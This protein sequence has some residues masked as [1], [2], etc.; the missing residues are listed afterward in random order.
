MSYLELWLQCWYQNWATELICDLFAIYTL[1][2]AYAWAHV[3]LCGKRSSDAFA[4]PTEKPLTHPA[5]DA[6][7]Q[8]M[9]FGLDR[10]GFEDQANA[11]ETRWDEVV[12][13]ASKGRRAEYRRC[14]PRELVGK[15]ET[16]AYEA[17]VKTGCR[18][19]G[20][21][22]SDFVHAILNEAWQ[23]FWND[24]IDYQGWEP[25]ALSRLYEYC[26]GADVSKSES[27]KAAPDRSDRSPQTQEIAGD[28]DA[29]RALF[30][31]A[32]TRLLRDIELNDSIREKH[33][34]LGS[35]DIL[36]L[37]VV[38]D[39]PIHG[40]L[41]DHVVFERKF[42]LS[43]K[44]LIAFRKWWEDRKSTLLEREQM[45][46]LFFLHEFLHIGQHVD[47]NTYRYSI[48]ADESFRFID[49][50]ADAFAVQLSLQLSDRAAQWIE[51]LPMILA[52]HVK[53]G[54]VFRLM[55]D[56]KPSD[57]IEGGRLQRQ[58][59]WHLQYARAKSFLPEARFEDFEIEKHVIIDL[60]KF[61]GEQGMQNLC[62][63]PNVYPAD[64]LAPVE[65]NLVWG[66]RRL[67]H[68]FSIRHYTDRLVDAI[69]NSNLPASL[70]VFRPLF[71][72]HP[73]LIGRSITNIATG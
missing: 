9:L 22:V 24:S 27:Q 67:R 2:P 15:I 23:T 51:A 47:S 19:V 17:F 73:E 53:C 16:I 61:D 52:E 50:Q 18:I 68:S 55:E 25:D 21:A 54:D 60:Y 32:L 41:Y 57:S 66:G 71:D 49:Y 26:E 5:D 70:E 11:I 35:N 56:G 4:V 58:L 34:L 30:A 72:E 40:G 42:F 12:K 36:G 14:Y 33:S 65:L 7:M 45:C 37:E 46:R 62:L 1:G 63:R 20:P 48:Q 64:L 6:R 10:L 13:V 31:D 69:F 39:E 38:P 59:L 3:H 43:N 8:V 28:V 29:E 44:L